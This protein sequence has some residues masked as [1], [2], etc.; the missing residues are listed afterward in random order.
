M[1][2]LTLG[3]GLVLTSLPR[4]THLR[5]AFVHQHAVD[6]LRVDAA[7]VLIR[8]LTVATWDFGQV[9]CDDLHFSY[10]PVHLMERKT[11]FFFRPGL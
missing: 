9:R 8:G 5:V 4:H 7:G 2:V 1:S 3:E 11:G 6:A 10:W